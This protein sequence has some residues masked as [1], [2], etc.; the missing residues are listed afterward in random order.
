MK[1]TTASLYFTDIGTPTSSEFKDIYFSNQ[2]GL[3]ESKHVFFDGNSLNKRFFSHE[4]SH[5]VIAETGFG[6]GLN[7]LLTAHLFLQF[8]QEKDAKS[9]LSRLYFITTEKFPIE[10]TQLRQALQH[11]PE[12][13][14][15]SEQ[16][17]VQYPFLT[18]GCHR[19]TFANGQIILDLWLGDVHNTFKELPIYPHG[20]VDAWY[21]D[22]FAPSKNPDMWQ[23]S[24]FEEMARLSKYDSTFATFTAAGIVKRGLR[25]NGFV[26]KKVQGF[27]KKRDMLTGYYSPGEAQAWLDSHAIAPPHDEQNQNKTNIRLHSE[28]KQPEKKLQGPWQRLAHQHVSAQQQTPEQNTPKV[29][30]I[31][32]GLAGANIALALAKK[33]YSV[34]V[35]CDHEQP[36]MGA[37][38]NHLGGFYPSL[39]ADF[40]LPSQFYC[41]AFSYAQRHYNSIYRQ[42]FEFAHDWCGVFFPAFSDEVKRRQQTLIENDIWPFELLHHIKA[43]K[44]EEITNL[45]MPYEGLFIPQGGW[46]NPSELVNAM[47]ANAKSFGVT[48]HTNKQ[49]KSLQRTLKSISDDWQLCWSDETSNQADL[50]VLA[51]GSDSVKQSYLAQIP[52]THSRGQVEYLKQTHADFTPA[53]VVCHKG[54]FT[55]FHE[56][57]QAMGATFDKRNLHCQPSEDDSFKNRNTIEKALNKCDWVTDLPESSEKRAAIRCSLPDHRPIVGGIPNLNNQKQQY[58]DMYKAL[59]INTYPLPDEY[60]GLYVLTGLG[61]HGLSTSPLLAE[62]LACQISGEPLPLGNELMASL[63]PNR[64]LIR[65]LIR[66]NI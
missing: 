23:N 28:K 30:V 43:D 59:P 40:S 15:L 2:N 24:L 22:G 57:K 4:S 65:D 48:V 11:W 55:P 3:E 60:K 31:G 26:V 1:L 25:Q 21:L 62:A 32:A 16:L 61:S 42:G 9:E 17:L 38:G 10:K 6:T 54:Y 20:L 36:A 51:T 47:L 12:F 7:F 14:Y 34:S 5:F 63:S 56:G 49:L 41:H 18:P 37:S 8:L 53:T 52:F 46:I 35:Y 45:H 13:Q 33:G 58:A 50:V 29:A 64:F 39:T 44:A 66:R 19:L 27:G